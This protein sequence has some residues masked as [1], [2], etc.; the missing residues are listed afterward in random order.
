MSTRWL[1]FLALCL[2]ITAVDV[3]ELGAATMD[4]SE[5]EAVLAILEKKAVG[6]A[7]AEADWTRLFQSEPYVRLKK[8]EAS[9]KRDFTD[10]DFRAFVLSDEL[11]ARAKEL[12]ATLD[13][14]THVDLAGAEA[15]A[16]AYL[17]HSATIRTKIYPVIKPR[18]NTFV[19]EVKTDPA[20]FVY[21]DP[22]TTP[23]DLANM[24]AHE[25]HHIGFG[26]GCPDPEVEK[27]L[28][29][30]PE[31]VA[32]VVRRLGA[33]GEGLAMLA[34]A[35]GPDV[36]PHE[37]SSSETRERW[38]RDVARAPEDMRTLEEFIVAA[39][40]GELQGDARQERFFSFY[41]EQGPW[42]TVGWLMATTIEEQLGR[43]ALLDA[44]CDPR[45]LLST[46]NRA[47]VKHNA[48][49]SKKRPLWSEQVVKIA[50]GSPSSGIESGN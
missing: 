42:Y 11:A 2:T 5:A 19:F 29:A 25:L 6:I 21:L 30:M 9:M 12:R 46:Y 49:T 16:R 3:P 1:T 41:G 36:H 10:D 39:A 24:L 17:S 15:R 4:S 8:R 22:R 31:G 35:G 28:E 50:S 34:A 27:E 44:F 38:D 18:T 47:V 33:F 40:G 13:G 23:D 7:V 32:W 43:A 37:T 26:G 20:I 48:G 14:W 45:T